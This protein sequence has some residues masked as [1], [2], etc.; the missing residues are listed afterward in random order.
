MT[1]ACRAL[2]HPLRRVLLQALSQGECDVG[3]LSAGLGVD[4]PTVSKHLAALRS[5]GLVQARVDG[6]RRCYSL[7]H[8]TVVKPLLGLLAELEARSSR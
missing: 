7:A 3:S 8:E 2:G 5:A 4:Q 1:S 6:R